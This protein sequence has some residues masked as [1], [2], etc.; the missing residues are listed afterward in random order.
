MKQNLSPL[1]QL[2]M[3]Q[4]KGGGKCKALLG[5]LLTES[6]ISRGGDGRTQKAVLL[7]R[8]NPSP[9]EKNNRGYSFLTKGK[10]ELS[11][12]GFTASEMKSQRGRGRYG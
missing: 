5:K 2:Q 6:A 9:T 8:G 4:S 12:L 11:F 3:R 7:E 10:K 1:A